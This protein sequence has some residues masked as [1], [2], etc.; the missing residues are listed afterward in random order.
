MV[1]QATRT[2]RIG[3]IGAGGIARQRHLPGLQKVEGVQF[4]AVANRRRET[5]EQ[6]AKE[7]NFEAVLDDWRQLIERDDIDAVFIAAPPYLH[8]DATIAAL[9]AGKHVFT[10]ARMAVNYAEAKRMYERSL[11]TDLITMISPPPHAMPGD[12]FIK[13]LLA[14]GFIGR[15]YDFQVR[16]QLNSYVDPNAPL[17]WRQDSDISGLNTLQLG[18]YSEVLHRWFGWQKR[19]QAIAKVHIPQRRRGQSGEMV[20]VKIADSLAIA[21]EFENGAIASWHCSGVTRFGGPNMLELYGSDGS[22]RYNIDTD[23]I[24]GARAGDDGLRRLEIPA[25]LR[26]EWLAEEEFITAIRAGN[27][28]VSPD[29]TEGIKYMEFTEAVYRSSNEGRAIDLPFDPGLVR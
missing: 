21:S 18:M 6:I 2:V 19:V 14:D 1:S 25:D 3:F 11:Q 17:H 4:V 29:F 26:R 15:P 8:A 7:Y 16:M 28:Q 24:L 5:A 13:K 27:R 23:E 10:Q 22:I 9:D 12:Y 20:E